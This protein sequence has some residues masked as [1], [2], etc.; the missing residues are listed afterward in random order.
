MLHMCMCTKILLAVEKTQIA[1]PSQRD[2]ID[3]QNSVMQRN[4]LEIDSL[5]KGPYHPI[6]C[7]GGPVTLLQLFLGTPTL[8]DSHTAEEDE[9]ICAGKHC[10]VETNS[11]KDFDI[12]ILED[13]LILKKLEPR[14]CGRTKDSCAIWLA[15]RYIDRRRGID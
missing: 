2:D 7:K 13:D 9:Q 4:Q 11:C 1:V 6:L 14:R 3:N 15:V 10:L 8:H 12:L 5:H